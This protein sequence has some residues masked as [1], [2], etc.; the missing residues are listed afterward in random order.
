LKQELA[1]LKRLQ[2]D[3]R[4]IQRSLAIIQSAQQILTF[5][6]SEERQRLFREYAALTGRRRSIRD[7]DA[8]P[9]STLAIFRQ[10]HPDLALIAEALEQNNSIDL[11]DL[12]LD[13]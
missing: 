5:Y 7:Q 6:T 3:C 10:D 2:E 1:L 13:I 11:S 4:S 8:N 12:K 9:H